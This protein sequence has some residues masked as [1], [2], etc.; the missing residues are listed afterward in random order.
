[1]SGLGLDCVKTRISQSCA[2]LFL[3]YLL[4]TEVASTTDFRIKEIETDFLHAS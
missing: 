2:E 1:M 4:A 3:N